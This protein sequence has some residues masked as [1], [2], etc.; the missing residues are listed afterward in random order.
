MIILVNLSDSK[1]MAEAADKLEA[2]G[3]TVNKNGYQMIHVVLLKQVDSESGT[4][5]ETM[6]DLKK[7]ILKL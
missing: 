2:N 4:V 6:E 7:K 5:A 1:Y 3:I